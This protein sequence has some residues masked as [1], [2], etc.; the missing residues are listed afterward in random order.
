MQKQQ[1]LEKPECKKE[2]E[3]EIQFSK[4]KV[5]PEICIK[6]VQVAPIYDSSKLDSEKVTVSA[7]IVAFI[8]SWLI[9]SVC[10]TQ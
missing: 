5:L 6:L 8:G 3:D 7:A 4:L 9:H 10:H 1:K 2:R